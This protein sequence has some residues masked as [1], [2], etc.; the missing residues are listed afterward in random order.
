MPS[1][2]GGEPEVRVAVTIVSFHS[3]ADL[4]SCLAAL[5]RSTHSD[6]EVVVCENGG[7]AAYETLKAALPPR[8][9]G[10]QEIRTVLA[11]GNLGYAGGVNLAM[12]QS[13]DA[14]AWW[15]LNPDTEPRPDALALQVRRLE[16]G[17]CDAVGCV[18]MLPSGKVQSY[19]GRW[20]P[21][22]ARAES[23]GHQTTLDT[24]V[25]VAVVEARQ[26]YLNGASMLIGRRFLA[27][28]GPMR[29]DYFLYCEEVEWCLRAIA[30]GMRLG[31]EPKAV[32]LHHQG[33]STGNAQDIR[34]KRRAPV[35]LNERNRLNTTRDVFPSHL[36][37]VVVVTFANLFVKYGRRGAWRQLG[38]GL[39]G[40]WA[41]VRGERGV[42]S[43]F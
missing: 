33:T 41:G 1:A 21:W 38:Y 10:G 16:R 11:Q 28:V 14:D 35:Y 24:A 8:L 29:E 43:W 7:P 30:G 26:S 37:V 18:V 31:F 19:G 17:D 22:I 20:F 25:D 36:P 42:P 4:V 40:W 15:V 39:Q 3:S 27:E 2:A 6:F 23:I 13:P 5:E 32:V 9:S 34:D 12:A